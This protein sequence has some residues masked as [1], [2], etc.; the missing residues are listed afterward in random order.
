MIE[1]LA[2]RSRRAFIAVAIYGTALFWVNHIPQVGVRLAVPHGDKYAHFGAYA[3]LAFLMAWTLYPDRRGHWRGYLIIFLAAM[4]Y[5][6]ADELLQAFVPGRYADW[7]DWI[8]DIGGASIGI[9]A[10]RVGA[11]TIARLRRSLQTSPA[12]ES[13]S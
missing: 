10:H 13:S 6:A 11:P 9:A 1:Q 7:W 5:G 2:R 4:S 12:A 3:L 8:A